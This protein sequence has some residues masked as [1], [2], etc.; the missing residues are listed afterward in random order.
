MQD[1]F[2]YDIDLILSARVPICKF[3]DAKTGVAV[4]LSFDQPSA[5]LTSLFVKQK[6][7]LRLSLSVYA[8]TLS[9]NLIRLLPRVSI[10]RFAHS[11]EASCVK[12]LFV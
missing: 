4:D 2:A 11:L 9:F 3:K 5:V 8:N 12:F 7:K 6:V 1:R 10:H